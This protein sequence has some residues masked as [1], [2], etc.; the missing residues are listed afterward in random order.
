M[1]RIL[2]FVSPCNLC[3]LFYYKRRETDNISFV[4]LVF[5]LPQ[6]FLSDYQYSLWNLKEGSI[7]WSK[8][9]HEVHKRSA[10]RLQDLCFRNGGIYI[11]LGQHI[12]QL[13]CLK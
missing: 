4:L 7:E 10:H 9:K 6:T 5:A 12:S 3:C 2:C 1:C 11:K 8:A 13:V